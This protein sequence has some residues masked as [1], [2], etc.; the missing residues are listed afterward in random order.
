M[1][2]AEIALS[3]SCYGITYV[4]SKSLSLLLT[5]VSGAFSKGVL[6]GNEVISVTALFGGSKLASALP[7]LLVVFFY[8]Q[9]GDDAHDGEAADKST[10][11]T[12]NEAAGG[13]G[14]EVCFLDR[15]ACRAS[16]DIVVV[17]VVVQ[18]WVVIVQVAHLSAVS[19][20]ESF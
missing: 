9:A 5:T 17:H 8:R 15:A 4:R 6:R 12:M 20:L 7:L 13:A 3:S 14:L 1:P 19:P 10:R 2:Y 18:V 11:G 16:H